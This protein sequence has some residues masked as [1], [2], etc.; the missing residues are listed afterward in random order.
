MRLR[1]TEHMNGF[2]GPGAP[3]YDT[4]EVIGRRDGIRLGFSLT[5]GAADVREVL[6]D[7]N[8]TLRARGVIRC[9]EFAPVGIA[10]S[11][12]TFEVFAPAERGRYAM[13]YRLPFATDRGPMT[14]LGFKD[15]GNDWGFDM[16]PDT[17]T[18]YTRLVCGT[19]EHDDTAAVP[20]YARGVL[21]LTAP[22]F[23]RQLTTLR[24]TPAGIG[25]FGLFFVEHLLAAYSGPRRSPLR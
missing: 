2:Y 6:R 3:G 18:L 4:G 1:F 10:V 24:G 22:M 7:P 23:A 8:H 17:T 5:I 15:V 11:D 25:L 19:A 9:K 13:R 16:W 20:D 21:R 14:L 12:G